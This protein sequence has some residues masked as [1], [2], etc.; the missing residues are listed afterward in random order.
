[1]TDHH[2]GP[3]GWWQRPL[4][5]TGMEV[6]ALGLGAGHIGN[7]DQ[8][9][10][11]VAELLHAAVDS[12]ITLIDTARG[13]GLSEERLG[14]HLNARRSGFVLVTKVGYDVEGFTDWTGS[15]I[16]A[17]VDAALQRLRTDQLDVVLLHSCPLDVLQQGDVIEA[18]ERNV[19]AGKVR[20]AGYS[21]E[22]EALRWAVESGHFSVIETSVNLADQRVIDEVLPLAQAQGIGVIAKRPLANAP[23]RFSERPVGDYAEPY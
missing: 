1:M 22:N 2:T 6:S 12:G 11:A 3:P 18:L 20:A 9:E 19:A 5:T 23:W 10:D 8:D 7:A 14:L 17:G 13:Y 15:I 21:G 4:G 16:S